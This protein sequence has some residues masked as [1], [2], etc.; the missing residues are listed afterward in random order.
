MK[1]KKRLGNVGSSIIRNSTESLPDGLFKRQLERNTS[2]AKLNN[3]GVKKLK[4]DQ[5]GKDSQQSSNKDLFSFMKQDTGR[6]SPPK[7]EREKIEAKF[8]MLIEWKQ[9]QVGTGELTS[10]GFVR[11]HEQLLKEK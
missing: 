10:N 1:P 8:D 3:D 7:T 4:K 5:G 6:N 2:S 11:K 9:R